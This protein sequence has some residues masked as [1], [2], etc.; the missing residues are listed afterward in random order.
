MPYVLT[1]LYHNLHIESLNLEKTSKI[2][3]H[4][5]QQHHVN[6]WTISPMPMEYFILSYNYLSYILTAY[7][8]PKSQYYYCFSAGLCSSQSLDAL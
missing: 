6:H 8:F 5:T 2:T 3:S 4:L 7:K 1:F